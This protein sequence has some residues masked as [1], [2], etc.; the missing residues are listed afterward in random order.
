MGNPSRETNI[1]SPGQKIFR[2]SW[3]QK[4]HYRF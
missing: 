2:L 1:R 4:F 3:H